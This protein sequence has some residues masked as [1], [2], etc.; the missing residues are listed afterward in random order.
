[1]ARIHGRHGKVFMDLGGSPGSPAGGSPFAPT[2]VGDVRSF[3]LSMKTDR[4]EVTAFGDANKQRV[5]GL[6]DYSGN[7]GLWYNSAGSTLEIIASILAGSPV[8]LKLMPDRRDPTIYFEGA[9]NLDGELNVDVNGAVSF[10][11]TWDAAGSW[12]MVS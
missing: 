8:G 5:A 6:P 7:I 11:G 2:E 3:T 1:M 4:V 12:E 10:D 9:A